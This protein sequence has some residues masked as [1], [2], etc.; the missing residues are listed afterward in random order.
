MN[1]ENPLQGLELNDGD[2]L[3]EKIEAKPAIKCQS[4]VIDGHRHLCFHPKTALS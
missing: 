2:P 3:Y 4:F 1:R